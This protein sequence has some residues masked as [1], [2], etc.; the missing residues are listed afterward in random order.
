MRSVYVEC[1]RGEAWDPIDSV[2]RTQ[3][4][5]TRVYQTQVTSVSSLYREKFV[6]HH[7]MLDR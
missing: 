6:D 2:W 1:G 5:Y 4:I 7:A 3:L